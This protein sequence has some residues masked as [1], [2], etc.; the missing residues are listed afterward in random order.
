VDRNHGSPQSSLDAIY[1]HAGALVAVKVIAGPLWLYFMRRVD[2]IRRL[3]GPS[4]RLTAK[5]VYHAIR[6]NMPPS[7]RHLA[8]QAKNT[9]LA[10]MR[11]A[12]GF[13]RIANSSWRRQ[14]LLILCY[15]GVSL[16]DEHEWNSS[17][18]MSPAFLRRRFEILR[19]GGY[20]VLDLGEGVSRLRAG[21]LPPRSVVLTFDDGLHDF[22]AKAVPLLEE[23]GFPA[24]NYVASY[25]AVKQRPLLNITLQYALWHGR[26]RIMKAHSFDGQHNDLVLSDPAQRQAL[27]DLLFRHSET[28]ADD[29]A[30]QHE[31]LG[32][33]VTKL[34]ADWQG[35]LERR[36]FHLMSPEEMAETKRRGFD[37]QLHTHRHRT[38]LDKALFLDELREN[39]RIVEA[40][41]GQAANHFCYPSGK[42]DPA[43]LPW[44]RELGVETATTCVADLARSDDDPLLL[45][46][47]TDTMGQSELVF[48]SWLAGVGALLTRSRAAH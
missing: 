14:R 33:V 43:F 34:G 26:E 39:R 12:G 15:H 22:L 30:A 32:E 41:T 48:E 2:A 1:I 44:L 47:F 25:Y 28:L 17:L 20:E 35:I 21:T 36:L 9:T 23:F 18:F 4:Q 46:R 8:R 7:F 6:T 3:S 16:H 42:T 38:P 45:P 13:E 24:T 31:W 19:D 37:L 5:P 27:F 11:A 40:S 29:R 10:G